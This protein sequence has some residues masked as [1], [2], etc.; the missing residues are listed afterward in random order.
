MI[1]KYL[2]L[3]KKPVQKSKQL[4]LFFHC[5]G[6]SNS[7]VQKKSR[8]K[9]FDASSPFYHKF[10]RQ[11]FWI[12]GKHSCWTPKRQTFE[13]IEVDTSIFLGYSFLCWHIVKHSCDFVPVWIFN[14]LFFIRVSQSAFTCSKLAIE[15]LEQSVKYVQS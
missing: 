14:L 6:S 4:V 15:T 7:C 2:K 1:F 13:E 9:R 3:V 11:L 5:F 12:G 10:Q 8:D